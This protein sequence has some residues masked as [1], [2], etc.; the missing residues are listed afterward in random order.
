M[1]TAWARREGEEQ[2]QYF[3]QVFEVEIFLC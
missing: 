3:F 1:G 2:A